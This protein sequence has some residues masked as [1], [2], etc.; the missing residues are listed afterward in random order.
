MITKRLEYDE[1]V[2]AEEV[3]SVPC[4]EERCSGCQDEWCG[5]DCHNR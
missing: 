1:S 5:H 3:L 4:T 2:P